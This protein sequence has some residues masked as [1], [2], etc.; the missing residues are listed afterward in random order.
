R[1]FH[2]WREDLRGYFRQQ[3]GFGYGRLDIVAKHPKR[4]GG[5][6]VSPT[7]MMLHPVLLLLALFTF[8]ADL[9]AHGNAPELAVL[10]MSLIASLLL[11]RTIAGVRTAFRFGDL[12]PLWFP[13]VHLV[14]DIAWVCAIVVWVFRRLVG[15]GLNPAHS[16]E[17]RKARLMVRLKPGTTTERVGL[18]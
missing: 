8:T 9:L 3:Y 6:A 4:V 12:T 14:R 18:K 17:E 2:R 1:S 15:E 16:M 10:G 11:E 5:D 7:F 13:L